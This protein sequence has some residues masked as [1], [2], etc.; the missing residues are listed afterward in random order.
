MGHSTINESIQSLQEML[1]T[2]VLNSSTVK[3]SL[4]D[5]LHLWATFLHAMKQVSKVTDSIEHT[6]EE[7]K[8]PQ[9]TLAEKKC[10][11]DKVK[12]SRHRKNQNH[13]C[14]INEVSLNINIENLDFKWLHELSIIG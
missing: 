5:C 11:L 14:E 2:L 6:L 1:S 7:A 4:E 13:I 3:V 10:Q 12:V 9:S 8:K